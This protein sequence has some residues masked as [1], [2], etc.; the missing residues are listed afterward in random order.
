MAEPSEPV[1]SLAADLRVALVRS[2]RR[3]R[4]ERAN[5][6]T[7][8]GEYSVLAR[9]ECDGPQTPRYLADH[10]HVQ[11]PTMSRIINGLGQKGMITRGP[12]PEDGRQVLVD[13]TSSGRAE[14]RETRRRRNEWLAQQLEGL[15]AHERDV[16]ARASEI[17]RRVVAR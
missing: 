1:V 9:L 13:L 2:V 10:D 8:D 6:E 3:I 5:E 7:T 11:P 4:A 15:D 14:V 12:H 16:L 17:L